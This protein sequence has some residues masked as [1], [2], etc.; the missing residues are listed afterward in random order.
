[1][2]SACTFVRQKQA[3]LCS[4]R[5]MAL[6]TSNGCYK[7]ILFKSKWLLRC[8]ACHALQRI[9]SAGRPS[10]LTKLLL[11]FS[12][13]FSSKELLILILHLRTLHRFDARCRGLFPK[14]FSV[15]ECHVLVL[16]LLPQRT[17]EYIFQQSHVI[18]EKLDL[19]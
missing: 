10:I 19:T 7:W 14:P 17:Y 2:L 16:L 6:Y 8:S 15:T 13:F 4:Q 18:M 11:I 12:A 3:F 1:M 9:I 5:M